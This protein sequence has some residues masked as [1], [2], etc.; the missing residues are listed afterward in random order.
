MEITIFCPSHWILGELGLLYYILSISS[1]FPAESSC[2]LIETAC[3]INFPRKAL[4]FY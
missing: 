1:F 4:N 2:Y 3:G